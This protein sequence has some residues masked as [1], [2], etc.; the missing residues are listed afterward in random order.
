MRVA[1]HRSSRDCVYACVCRLSLYLFD[2]HASRPGW[3]RLLVGTC[4][5]DDVARETVT[6]HL[7][8]GHKYHGYVAWMDGGPSATTSYAKQMLVVL[9]GGASVFHLCRILFAG[10]ALPCV[11]CSWN[12]QTQLTAVLCRCP[13]ELLVS[14][15]DPTA[16][17]GARSRRRTHDRTAASCQAARLV[18]SFIG[19]ALV[20]LAPRMRTAPPG[21]S[22]H[23]ICLSHPIE[24]LDKLLQLLQLRGVTS[25]SCLI[26]SYFVLCLIFEFL[27]CCARCEFV[28]SFCLWGRGGVW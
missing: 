3:K 22:R 7:S 24:Y 15:V 8:P 28:L 26:L 19:C 21:L 1:R 27:V 18:A 25:V 23:G 5:G 6:L 4:R 2:L 10:G 17:K 11:A 9:L 13:R 12:D 16:H 14:R 20:L